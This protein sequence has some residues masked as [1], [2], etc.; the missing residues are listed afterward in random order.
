M[1]S[2]IKNLNSAMTTQSIF[3]QLKFKNFLNPL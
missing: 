3:I 2:K 1:D